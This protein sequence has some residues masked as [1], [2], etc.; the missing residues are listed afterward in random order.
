MDLGWILDGLGHILDNCLMDF[1]WILDGLGQ[2]LMDF[3]WFSW[4]DLDWLWMGFAWILDGFFAWIFFL[5]GFR[6]DFGWF[7]DAFG[8]DLGQILDGCLM[9]FGWFRINFD[10]FC[11]TVSRMHVCIVSPQLY[12]SSIS[13]RLICLYLPSVPRMHM[14]I[15]S[16]ELYI[17]S[18][19]TR[20]ICLLSPKRI[21]QVLDG[22]GEILMEFGWFRKK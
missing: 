7:Q 9:D 17:S 4:M 11:L 13:T 8:M 2:I 21:S 6:M 3:G 20:L 10:G 1:A 16:P 15:L 18:I 12:I 14:C 5:H 19:S 22:L